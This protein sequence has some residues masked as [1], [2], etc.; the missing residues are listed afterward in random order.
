[1]RDNNEEEIIYLDEEGYNHYMEDIE[2]L[3]RQLANLKNERNVARSNSVGE[4]WHDN[5]AI[6]IIRREEIRISKLLKDALNRMGLILMI[7]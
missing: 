5:S 7:L 4:N 1:M 3:K 6:E 2:N